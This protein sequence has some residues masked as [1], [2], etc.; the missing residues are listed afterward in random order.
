MRTRE[1]KVPFST[2]NGLV[3]K[4]L[5]GVEKDNDYITIKTECDRSF[6]LY[7]AQDCCE[8]VELNDF[9][10]DPS[11]LIGAYIVSAEERVNPPESPNIDAASSTW[12]FYDIQ[13]N[14]GYLWLRFLGISNGYYSER[15]TFVEQIDMTKVE[16][17]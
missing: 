7:H 9:D 11:D 15:M 13:T 8:R 6:I 4:S 10:G 5:E 14:K 1:I 17:S 2:L 16:V 3:I 12:T